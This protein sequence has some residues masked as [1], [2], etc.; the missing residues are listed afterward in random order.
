MYY[1]IYV[2]F[3]LCII[4][5]NDIRYNIIKK[6]IELFIGELFMDKKRNVKM[7]SF[8]ENTNI[9]TGYLGL[10]I[11]PMYSGKT[12]KLIELYKQFRFCGVETMIINYAE[13]T[14]Y[15]KDMLSTHDLNMV[16]CI[17]ANTLSEVADI[18][19][20]SAP[21][22][23]RGATDGEATLE[24]YTNIL[25]QES[26]EHNNPHRG[27]GVSPVILINEG[28][29]FK[30]IVEWVTVAVNKYKKCVYIC[31]LDGDFKRELFGNWLDLIPLCDSVEK[32]HSFCSGCKRRPALFSHRITCEKEQKVIGSSSKYVPLCRKCYETENER[33]NK[34]NDTINELEQFVNELCE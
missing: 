13:D 5:Y 20:G 31:G 26:K 10:F 30:D 6:R 18:T 33:K 2:L 1:F 11:G 21:F 27:F 8:I 12:S 24:R 3:H 16:P 7:A 4:S 19:R 17:M 14:R 28:Q 15:S 22:E 32:L 25:D 34:N 29:F 9:E 23:P